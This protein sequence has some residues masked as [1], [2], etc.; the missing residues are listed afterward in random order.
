MFVPLLVILDWNAFT[1]KVLP[2]C[3]KR[4]KT[5][6]CL[7][8][9]LSAFLFSGCGPSTTPARSSY[10]FCPKRSHL[11]IYRILSI[12]VIINC[13]TLAEESPRATMK[14]GL[15]AYKSGVY[16]NAVESLKKTV[17]TYPDLGHYN[18]GAAYFKQHAF[19]EADTHFQ[20]ALRSTDFSPSR[21]IL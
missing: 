6:V 13:T 5:N 9:G 8:Y 2:I 19:K 16:T 21:C 3:R 14:K 7:A 15:R 11:M 1:T 18:L 10:S 17:L 20:E 4:S 12:L